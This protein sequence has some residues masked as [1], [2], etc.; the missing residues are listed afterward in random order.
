[1]SAFT[2]E[3]E[4]EPGRLAEVCEAMAAR[5]VN[6]VICGLA[7]GDTGT[8]AFIADDEAAARSVL[9]DAGFDAAERD[10]LTVRLKNAP[11]AGAAT[12]RKLADAGVNVEV[13]L[14]V[15]VSNSQFVAVLCVDDQEAAMKVLGKAVI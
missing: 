11:G 6:L 13:F 14:P 3:F 9:Q 7:H 1:M 5:G 8:V 12:F 15:R 4:N 10:A 2:V